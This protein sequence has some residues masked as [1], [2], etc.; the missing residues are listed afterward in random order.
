MGIERRFSQK[1]ILQISGLMLNQS[2]TDTLLSHWQIRIH[3]ARFHCA[4]SLQFSEKRK[5]ES[6]MDIICKF[7][8]PKKIKILLFKYAV[9]G[10]FKAF[11][12]IYVLIIFLNL[13]LKLI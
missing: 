11:V 4:P 8:L 9:P 13:L 2:D 7:P 6:V 12:I 10:E 1:R 3:M 5:R